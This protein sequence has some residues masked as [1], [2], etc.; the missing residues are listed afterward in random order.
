[1]FFWLGATKPCCQG[2][3]PQPQ[4]SAICGYFFDIDPTAKDDIGPVAAQ[5]CGELNMTWDFVKSILNEYYVSFLK[6]FNYVFKDHYL[7]GDTRLN[8]DSRLK[9]DSRFLSVIN[10]TLIFYSLKLVQ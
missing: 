4:A 8:G 1:M 9:G 3:N 5:L 7:N 2:S 6:E 10:G